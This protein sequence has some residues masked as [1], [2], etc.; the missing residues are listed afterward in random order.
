MSRMTEVVRRTAIVREEMQ[1]YLH[2]LRHRLTHDVSHKQKVLV[3]GSPKTGTTWMIKLLTSIPGYRAAGNFQGQIERY[4][5]V[6]AGDVVH[7][8]DTLTPELAELL[9]ANGIKTILMV[10]DPRDQVVSRMFH[11]RRETTNK[12]HKKFQEM[13]DEEAI[14]ACIEG[15]SGV[16][17]SLDLVALTESW[18]GQWDEMVCIKYEELIAHPVEELCKVLRYLEIPAEESFIQR[19]VH[20][21]RFERL[22]IGKKFWKTW[23]VAGQEDSNSHFR[24]GIVG[25]WTNYFTPEHKQRFKEVAGRTLIEWG[26]EKDPSW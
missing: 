3:N 9:K 24:K 26:Y 16:R 14:M 10:R 21:N 20:R 19:I 2:T 8:H 7:G 17:S 23:R 5:Q 25:D 12:V 18:M 22:A 4:A 13:S 15:G 6:G 1:F 11:L